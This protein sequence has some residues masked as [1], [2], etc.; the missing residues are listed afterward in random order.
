MDLKTYIKDKVYILHL[1]CLG[2][3][4]SA[5]SVIRGKNSNIILKNILKVWI[6]YFGAPRRFLSDNGGEFSNDEFREL[7]EQLNIVNITTPGES[8]W[9]N[10]VVER[11]NGILME[12]VRRT[13]DECQCD[14]ETALPWALSAKNTLSN[15]SGYAPNVLVFGRNPSVPS[16]LT[17]SV[18][19]LEPC[20]VSEIVRV[21]LKVMHSARKAY[22]AAE[23]SEKIRRALRMKLRTSNDTIVNSGDSVFYRRENFKGWKGPGTVIGRDRKLVVVRHGGMVYRVPV[24]HIMPVISANQV[25][26]EVEGDDRDE[27]LGREGDLDSVHGS[28]V[29]N[30]N[31][32]DSTVSESVTGSGN[33]DD[34]LIDS[35]IENGVDDEFRNSGDE[36]WLQSNVLPALRSTVKFKTRE[37]DRWQTAMILGKRRKISWEE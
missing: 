18:P 7:C 37:S 26:N 22:V 24:C 30:S 25:G 9:S 10:G 32:T 6:Q 33:L 34:S 11:H 21:N 5:A 27:S 1:I 28:E 13:M 3:K 8:P 36:E 16:V 14:L 4:Y 19:A 15:V 20:S 17:D 23:S 29:E 35:S 31:S 12:T 2:T